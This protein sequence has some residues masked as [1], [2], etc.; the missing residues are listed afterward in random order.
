MR[1][2]PVRWTARSSAHRSPDSTRNDTRGSLR[3]RFSFFV[4][5]GALTYTFSSRATNHTGSAIGM[6]SDRSVVRMPVC[7]PSS[8]AHASSRLS[9]TL[10]RS[11]GTAGRLLRPAEDQGAGGHHGAGGDEDVLHVVGLV[12]RGSPDQ[13]DALGDPV[14]AVDVGL[15]ELTAVGVDR[16]PAPELDVAVAHEVL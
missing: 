7:A 15:A 9:R 2:R 10:L 13:A 4:C 3:T 14:H 6:P 1:A 16:Q 8:S 12:R 11:P 5:A